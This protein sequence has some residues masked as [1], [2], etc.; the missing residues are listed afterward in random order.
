M[1][2]QKQRQVMAMVLALLLSVVGANNAGAAESDF[3][4]E[5]DGWFEVTED[6]L[7]DVS[8]DKYYFAFYDWHDVMLGLADANLQGS[9]NRTVWFQAPANPLEDRTKLWCMETMKQVSGHESQ[10][11]LRSYVAKDYVMESASGNLPRFIVGTTMTPNSNS[12]VIFIKNENKQGYWIMRNGCASSGNY[13]GPWDGGNFAAPQE[14]AFNKNNSNDYKRPTQVKIYAIPRTAVDEG[15]TPEDNTLR[16]PLTPAWI[17]GHIVWEDEKNT[18]SAIEGL[19]DEYRTRDIPVHAT[20]IDSPWSTAFNNFIWDTERYPDYNGMIDSFVEKNVKV[21]L[22]LTGCV[23]ETSTGCKQNKCEE[24]DNA[25]A[26]GY[27]VN[28]SQPSKWWK[29]SG[30]QIDFTNPDATAWWYTQ[31]DKA[32]REGVYGW[33]VDQGEVYFGDALKT[34]IG[35]LTNEQFRPYYYNAMEDYIKSKNPS[36]GANISRPYSHQKGFHSD[37][38]E[39]TMGWCG[40]FAGDWSGLKLQI[41]NIYKSTQAGYAAVGT[42]VA[43]F[44][45]AKSNKTQFI[46]YAQFGAMTACMINGGENGAFTNHLPWWHGSDVEAIYRDAVKLHTSLIPYLFSVIV[47]AH[48]NGGTLIQNANLVNE[49]HMLGGS[50][51][52][53]AITSDAS[54]V[55]VS[56]PDEGNWIDWFSGS[57]F[58]GGQTYNLQY[59]LDKFPLFIRQGDIIPMSNEAGVTTL[60][61]YPLDG[62]LSQATFHLPQGDGIEYDDCTVSLDPEQGTLSIASEKSRNYMFEMKGVKAIN[63][64]TGAANYSFDE[65]T[66]VLRI[67]VGA[68]TS[69]NITL[70]G[71]E[72]DV[73][74]VGQDALGMDKASVQNPI[75]CSNL[76]TDHNCRQ[77]QSWTGSGRDMQS[78]QH[79]S[80]DTSR[81]YYDNNYEHGERYVNVVLPR[82]GIYRLSASVR[83]PE[84]SNVGSFE[85]GDV[86][87]VF[88]GRG[89][90]G[91]T[92]ATDGTEWESIEEGKSEGKTFANGGKGYGWYYGHI[93][94]RTDGDSKTVRLRQVL[95]PDTKSNCGGITLE[96]LGNATDAGVMT[97]TNG[98]RTFTGA[99]AGDE[100]ETVVAEGITIIDLTNAIVTD[101]RKFD[102][103]DSPNAIIL[104]AGEKVADTQDNVVVGQRIRHLRFIDGHDVQIPYGL[105]AVASSATLVRT[106]LPDTWNT[107]CLP[108][109]LSS[110]DLAGSALAAANIYSFESSSENGIRFT[111]CNEMTGGYPYVI[112][113]PNG[114][115]VTETVFE[116]I[117]LTSVSGHTMGDEDNVQFVGVV[118]ASELAD[119]T[120]VHY[121]STDMEMKECE[122][123]YDIGAL[124]S[125]FIVPNRNAAQIDLSFSDTSVAIDKLQTDP[126]KLTIYDLTGRKVYDTNSVV[127]GIVIKDGK[128]TYIR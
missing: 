63:N 80:G 60:C 89:Y 55:S 124:R 39:M 61:C 103:T 52:T 12:G 128:K 33:K 54:I 87:V 57:V 43:G 108:F 44:M 86:S 1:S 49:S 9:G 85:F 15:D 56:L 94:L 118:S 45:G 10:Y 8:L 4:K 35:T 16:P 88:P 75:D 81:E 68:T 71:L 59:S 14:C 58:N 41:D 97:T 36:A 127:P 102:V 93:V 114:T 66:G 101:C 29:G 109:S 25:V 26:K 5:T 6:N 95:T 112:K 107:I 90:E 46:R 91:G 104:S 70:T 19:V 123:D 72:L 20:I 79:W 116:N 24:Y 77:K 53:K 50:L 31:L 69:A 51:F 48:L 32:Y 92:I 17:L 23:N 78:G 74:E 76:I 28:D 62:T 47:N 21:M 27:G 13:L 3:L 117:T 99:F 64:V 22:W 37:P 30:I 98:R 40:D 73:L 34:S 38:R 100:L 125:Y 120:N 83:A 126:S 121:L 67:E 18:Q 42:E 113:L 111:A 2:L 110:A 106:L 7:S 84:D 119:K 96:Y 65:T 11:T 105:T 122:S 115:N 82:A